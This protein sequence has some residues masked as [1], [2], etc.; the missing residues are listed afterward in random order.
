MRVLSCSLLVLLA[1]C[2]GTSA[3][4]GDA[5]GTTPDGGSSGGSSSGGSSSGGSSSGGSSSGG[6]SSGGSSSG[7]DSGSGGFDAQPAPGDGTPQRVTCTS[8]LGNALSTVHGRIDG[9][10]VALV[11]TTQKG[12]NSDSTHLHLQIAMNGST[13]DVAVNLDAL[14]D[15]LD[16]PLPDGPWAEGWHST[17]ALDYVTNLGLH[18]GTFTAGTVDGIQQHL[19]AALANVNHI[20]IFAT[21]YGPDGAHLVH[22]QGGGRDGAIFI[23]PLSP[24]AHGFVFHFNTQTF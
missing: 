18:A 4:V 5:T 3:P 1:A 24:T 14:T 16:A 21:G 13:Y 6:S 12:C 19:V 15:E 2:G 11:P 8:S 20:S 10:L 22:R 9:R 17:M 23:D 7:G